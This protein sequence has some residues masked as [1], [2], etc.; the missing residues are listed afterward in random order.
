MEEV[1]RFYPGLDTT[2][3]LARKLDAAEAL[4]NLRTWED[5]LFT[6]RR[7]NVQ[8][9]LALESAVLRLRLGEARAVAARA[10]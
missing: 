9:L 4:Q 6:L 8:E 10:S 3:Q 2:Q 1:R 5:L 7:T